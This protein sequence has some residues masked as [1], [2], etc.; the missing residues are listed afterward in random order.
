MVGRLK[1]AA[2]FADLDE[3]YSCGVANVRSPRLMPMGVG[4]DPLQGTVPMSINPDGAAT[5]WYFD[6]S[7]VYRCCVRLEDES[8]GKSCATAKTLRD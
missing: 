2:A 7:S 4:I 6:S 3:S 1:V 8:A 5:G